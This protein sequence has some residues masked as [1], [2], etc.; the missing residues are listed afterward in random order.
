MK[1]NMFKNIGL[2]NSVTF[3]SVQPNNDNSPVRVNPL[4]SQGPGTYNNRYRA[5]T[6]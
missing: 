1:N 4:I 3:R 2:T 5:T 6:P